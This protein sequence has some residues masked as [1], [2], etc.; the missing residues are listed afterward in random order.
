MTGHA[1]PRRAL[2]LAT[3]TA[4]AATAVLAGPVSRAAHAGGG[5]G[6]FRGPVRRYDGSALVLYALREKVGDAAFRKIE[7]AW[8]SD[9]RG[10]SAGTEDFIA[11]ASRTARQDLDP[12]LTPWLYGG[13]TPPMPNHPDWTV[14]PVPE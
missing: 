6:G 8:V 12:F 3:A 14:A 1:L 7:R 2:R 5:E 9:Y 10:R 4:L 13:R 11:L